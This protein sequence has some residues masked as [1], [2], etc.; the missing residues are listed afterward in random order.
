MRAL[1]DVRLR[2]IVPADQVA[3]AEQKLGARVDN[4]D[5]AKVMVEFFR[6]GARQAK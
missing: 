6:R 5:W 3:I 2:E 1:I 4:P